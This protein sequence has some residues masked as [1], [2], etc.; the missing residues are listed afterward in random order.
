MVSSDERDLCCLYVS[1]E[2]LFSGAAEKRGSDSEAIRRHDNDDQRGSKIP[3]RC[4]GRSMTAYR[5]SSSGQKQHI[6]PSHHYPR[7]PIRN[8]K[9]LTLALS[10][11]PREVNV[12]YRWE[13][14]SA[15]RRCAAVVRGSKLCRIRS[16]ETGE[17]MQ[18]N[19]GA[20]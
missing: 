18:S 6:E 15:V 5:P 16:G 19:R 11:S 2:H 17:R 9:I 7:D 1:L 14:C 3:P 12:Q 20:P 4:E 10:R 8:L 13:V